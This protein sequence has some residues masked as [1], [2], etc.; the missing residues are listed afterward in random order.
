MNVTGITS[1]SKHTV[2]Y[3]D[4]PSALRPVPYSEE[5]PV[6]KHL[7]ILTFNDENS[8]SDKDCRQQE[9]DNTD[10]IPT[11]EASCSS[12]ELHLISQGFLNDL[13]SDMNLSKKQAEPSGSTSNGG[14]FFSTKILKYVSFA[15]VKTNSIAEHLEETFHR[16]NIAERQTLLLFR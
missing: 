10:C 7:E 9:R 4:L 12:S 8:N 13:V 14:I 2:N 6:P 16:Q 3:P 1:K 11:F 15:I 5:L